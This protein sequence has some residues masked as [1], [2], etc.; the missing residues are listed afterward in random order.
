MRVYMV[1]TAHSQISNFN[2]RTGI[3]IT[4]CMACEGGRLHLIPNSELR[5]IFLKRL[6]FTGCLYIYQIYRKD[7]LG[8]AWNICIGKDLSQV[9]LL[10]Q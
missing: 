10:D 3:L 5:K 7:L 2:L 4:G 9:H 8:I 6:K 1:K